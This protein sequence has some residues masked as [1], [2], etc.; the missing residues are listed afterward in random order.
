MTTQNIVD[1]DFSLLA[2]KNNPVFTGIT[3]ASAGFRTGSNPM[4]TL[5]I[6]PYNNTSGD[7]ISAADFIS[8]IITVNPSGTQTIA[9]PSA[10]D[11]D[12]ALAALFGSIPVSAVVKL[13]YFNQ[14][15]FT[16][17]INAGSGVTFTRGGASTTVA[18][19]VTVE[20]IIFKNTSSP[21]YLIVGN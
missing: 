16:S 21:A 12:S 14:S 19:L 8:G 13:T 1:T 17:T 11:I 6:A 2:P 7:T 3:N 20:F 4:V 15:S 18:A 5:N 10:S 9:S